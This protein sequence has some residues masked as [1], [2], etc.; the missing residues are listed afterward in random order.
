MVGEYGPR[1][2]NSL[3]PNTIC[4]SLPNDKMMHKSKFNAFADD[5][6]NIDEV[7]IY[8]CSRVEN[9]VGK[10]K[11]TG[12]QYYLFPPQCFQK[13]HKKGLSKVGSMAELYNPEKEA[14]WKHCGKGENAGNQYFLLFPQ[15]F[16]PF[17]KQFP[18]FSVTFTM[19][20]AN[21]FTFDWS[22]ILLLGTE[23][24]L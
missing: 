12:Y 1:T 23:I 19:S 10:G 20:S 9:I 3:L 18:T 2:F 6:F 16:L 17:W 24:N 8:T 13:A 22:K 4:N 14:F 7:V 5:K 15:C 11:N 21:A